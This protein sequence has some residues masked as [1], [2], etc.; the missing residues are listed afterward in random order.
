MQAERLSAI[1]EISARLAHD[2]RNPLTVIKGTVE[3]VKAKSKRVFR[4]TN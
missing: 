3:I 4:K 1:G 2:L